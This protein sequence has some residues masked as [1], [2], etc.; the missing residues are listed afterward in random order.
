M[1]ACREY[2]GLLILLGFI[3]YGITVAGVALALDWNPLTPLWG[4][5][6]GC[7]FPPVAA[8]VFGWYLWQYRAHEYR[9]RLYAY[10][11]VGSV[12]GATA[13]LLSGIGI[14]AQQTAIGRPVLN[15]GL[16]VSESSLSGGL[17]GLAT[18][19]VY[20]IA[21][22]ERRKLKRLHATTQDLILASDTT[23]VAERTVSSAERILGLDTSGIY[24]PG[25]E[26]V[27]EPIAATERTVEVFGSVPPIDSRESIAWR[28]YDSG[29]AEFVDDVRTH[30]EV[31][32]SDTPIRSE[33]IIPVG[34]FGV[35]LAASTEAG[36]FDESDRMLAQVLLS[37]A[38]AALERVSHETTLRERERK[39]TALQERLERL[40]YTQTTEKTAREAISTAEDVIGAAATGVYVRDE[41]GSTLREVATSAAAPDQ[42]ADTP[43]FRRGQRDGVVG[44]TAWEVVERGEPVYVEDAHTHDPSPSDPSVRCALV[45]PVGDRGVF[46]TASEHPCSFSDVERTL[47]A[48][49]ASMLETAL[50]RV[51]REQTL[52]QSESGLEQHRQRL[53]VLNRV[54]RHDIRNTASLMLG[55]TSKLSREVGDAPALEKLERHTHKIVELSKN[56]RRVENTIEDTDDSPTSVDVTRTIDLIVEDVEATWQ[57]ADVRVDTPARAC[58]ASNGLIRPA[59]ENVVTNAVEHNDADSPRVDVSVV[60]ESDDEVLIRVADDGPGIP[61]YEREIFER[62]EETKLQHS[63]GLGLWLVHWIIED[64]EG[65]V[66]IVQR[67]PRGTAVELRVPRATV[68]GESDGE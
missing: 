11:G 54:L 2:M 51:E 4:H 3:L 58:V 53:T 28:G 60:S 26:A 37:N 61:E 45:Y 56:A 48:V 5:V 32:N 55:E 47:F 40:M 49:L 17:V 22:A 1:T 7:A 6:L 39:L 9:S 42:L 65:S 52:R 16:F 12:V 68:R 41:S 25:D 34:D 44:A 31:Y 59:I 66:E 14:T 10:A 46:V 38:E 15:A 18:G 63:S 67:Q 62:R 27:L 13:F 24:V 20:G 19:H 64:M 23:D 57:D 43:C 36:A 21:R 30:P 35:F 29:N 8:V 50:D 33:M